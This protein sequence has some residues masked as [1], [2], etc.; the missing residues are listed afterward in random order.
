MYTPVMGDECW[1]MPL[2]REGHF[3]RNAFRLEELFLVSIGS[4]GVTA[5]RI[6]RH[7][8]FDAHDRANVLAVS[9]K[10]QFCFDLRPELFVRRVHATLPGS[11]KVISTLTSTRG[12]DL[13]NGRFL[14]PVCM[15]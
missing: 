6:A 12:C 14:Q 5:R 10:P 7:V 1:K 15:E 8:P 3:G 9:P 2:N 4:A 13:T 11:V